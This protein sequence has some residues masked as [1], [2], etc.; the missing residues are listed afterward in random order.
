MMKRILSGVQ[1]T[2]KLTI[3]N[4]L[5]AIR[6][7]VTLQHDMQSL[8]C[9][10]DLHAITVPQDPKELRQATLT[11]AAAY[12]A[13][14]I[15][16]KTSPIFVQSHVPE[17]TELAW[18][19]GCMTPMGWLSR[20]TQF[21]DKAG[22]NRDQAGLGLF[23]YPTLMAADILLYKSTHVPV[24]DDQKQH[25]EMTRDLAGSFNHTYKA[26]FFPLPEP[27]ILGEAKRIM[28]LRDGTKKMSKSDP[29]EMARIHLTDSADD[30]ALKIRKAKTDPDALPDNVTALEQRP[31]AKNLVTIYAALMQLSTAKALEALAGKQFAEFKQLL[32][33]L[34]IATVSPIREQISLLLQD[35]PALEA[36]L[37]SGAEQARS[38]AAPTLKDVKD[39][40]GFYT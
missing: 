11:A 7:W 33:D 28:S 1:P 9:V 24:G 12:I 6:N 18:I 39:L 20:M 17:H 37:K 36:L 22:K 16:P 40:V 34:I 5:G 35:A 13:C 23:A 26:D 10:V 27:L 8:F 4:Y 3:G 31:E 14:G 25:L 38:I 15:D 32:A 2:N 29:S 30:I 19:L 21:K